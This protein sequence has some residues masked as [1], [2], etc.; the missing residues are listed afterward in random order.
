[1]HVP[2]NDLVVERQQGI[3]ENKNIAR[4]EHT[5]IIRFMRPCN[6]NVLGDSVAIIVFVLGHGGCVFF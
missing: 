5:N 3:R 4:R 1:M 2:V 6:A